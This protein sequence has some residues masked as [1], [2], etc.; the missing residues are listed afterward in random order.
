M[1]WRPPGSTPTSSPAATP[2]APAR[3]AGPWS[4]RS[5]PRQRSAAC[6]S[7]PGSA[8]TTCSGRPTA[9]RC[10]GAAGTVTARAVVLASGG[11][12][13]NPRL[14]EA[15]LP[16]PVTPISAPSNTGDGLELGLAAGGA[17]TAMRAVLGRPGAAGPG[18]RLRRATRPGRMANVELTLPGSIMVN[19][20]GRRFVNEAVNYHDLNKVFRTID[21][22]TGGHANIPAWLVVDSR[23]RVA[24]LD[25]RHAGR[26]GC[27]PGPSAP[28]HRR[29]PRR[30]LRIDPFG[31]RR[32]GC[33]VQ[34]V[35]RRRPRPAVPPRGERRRPLPRRRA[36]AAP[37]PGPAHRRR[38][39]TRSRSGPAPWAP[40]AGWS[41]T[42]TAGCSTERD[43]PSAACSP[44]ATSRHRVRR[45]LSR[46]R[47]HPRLRRHPGLRRRARAGRRPSL[48][49]PC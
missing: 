11:F 28:A 45:R 2:R 41:P 18:A 25:R 19:A 30:G 17:V 10:S 36:A 47:C 33:R 23:L 29:R 38:R 3:W 24:L 21:P 14:Q 9:G 42:T 5:S 37:L 40:A 26:A 20:A 8:S 31:A 44:P 16:N 7:W 49:P 12:E 35:R 15:F 48:T 6:G 13:W 39:S 34:Q 27:R 4:P 32:D 22:N 43:G 1:R 46:R